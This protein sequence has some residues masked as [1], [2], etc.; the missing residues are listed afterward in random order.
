MS[1]VADTIRTNLARITELKNQGVSWGGISDTLIQE[2]GVSIPADTL[3][4]TFA[5]INKSSGSDTV[6][7]VSPEKK[8]IRAATPRPEPT[9]KPETP[10]PQVHALKVET[11]RLQQEVIGLNAKIGK[12]FTEQD[13]RKLLDK[14]SEIQ[15][16]ISESTDALA[17]MKKSNEDLNDR[18]ATLNAHIAAATATDNEYSRWDLRK[19]ITYDI[20]RMMM[21][22][23]ICSVA[24]AGIGIGIGVVIRNVSNEH[25]GWIVSMSSEND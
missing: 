7:V 11:E 24:C 1:G 16:Q 17:L 6:K 15:T 19:I 18:I 8:A 22:A 20:R 9:T 21:V 13:V 4:T 2:T 23:A 25:T 10:D 12:M 5:R 14:N 3:R